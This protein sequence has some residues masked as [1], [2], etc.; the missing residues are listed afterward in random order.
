MSVSYDFK[1]GS[2]IMPKMLILHT[3]KHFFSLVPPNPILKGH[4]L[5]CAKRE[6]SKYSE[7]HN[8]E[9]FDFALTV[10][11]MSKMLEGY[12]K[13]SS[14]TIDIQEGEEAGQT[15]GHF[16]AH[17]IP[18]SKGDLSRNDFIYKKLRVFDDD[19][20]RELGD[21][22]VNQKNQLGIK[23]EVEKVK[24]YLMNTYVY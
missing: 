12:Y 17:I 14:C 18:R 2:F 1:F 13:T 15:I 5:I 23:E 7:L 21:L 20:Y 6:V 19:F 10:Q 9:I 22:Q 8:E 16:H 24:S 4:I 3:S 11:Y